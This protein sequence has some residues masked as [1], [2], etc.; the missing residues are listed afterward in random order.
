MKREN[1]LSFNSVLADS[2][3]VLVSFPFS[4]SRWRFAVSKSREHFHPTMAMKAG[5][6]FGKGAWERAFF[7][8]C[9]CDQV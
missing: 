7:L 5:L 4:S 2:Y 3:K 6:S 1:D 9:S 8:T